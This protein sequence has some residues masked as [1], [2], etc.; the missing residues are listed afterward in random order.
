MACGLP[1]HCSEDESTIAGRPC[2]ALLI[3]GHR[4]RTAVSS[5]RCTGDGI[6]L[7]SFAGAGSIASRNRGSCTCGSRAGEQRATAALAIFFFFGCG[8]ASASAGRSG[9]YESTRSLATCA[10]LEEGRRDMHPR[11]LRPSRIAQALSPLKSPKSI[12]AALAIFPRE[13]EGVPVLHSILQNS[14]HPVQISPC[15]RVASSQ[16]IA[17]TRPDPGGDT[18]APSLDL[19]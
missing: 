9:G 13:D 8:G 5:H 7:V 2:S 4:P 1:L 15:R 17:E 12:S 11:R 19:R 3:L 10:R 18:S 14:T 6:L 16:S